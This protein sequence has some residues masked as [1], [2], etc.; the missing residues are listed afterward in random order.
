MSYSK[1]T[2]V[3][4]AEKD[5]TVRSGFGR[6]VPSNDGSILPWLHRAHAACTLR[7]DLGAAGTKTISGQWV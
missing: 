3:C 2:I 6:K 4:S 7:P 5:E 1:V